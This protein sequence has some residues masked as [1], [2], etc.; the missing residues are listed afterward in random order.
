MSNKPCVIR[1]TAMGAFRLPLED[2]AFARREIELEGSIDRAKAMDTIR[3]MRFLA[4]EGTEKPITLLINS[5]GGSV[6]DGLAIFDTMR[7]LPCPVRTIC[8]GEASS[9]ASVILAGGSKGNR[10]ILPNAQVMIHDPILTGCGGPALTVDAISQRLMRTRKLVAEIMAECTGKSVE[11][12]LEKTARDT[13][14]T[15]NEA[16]EF[17]LVD[18]VIKTWGGGLY[19]AG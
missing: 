7:A 3:A 18:S 17:G 9:M 1:D 16:V 14:F 4:E 13:F 15:A 8:A 10:F 11:E 6:V 12:I 5:E 19:A 2:E